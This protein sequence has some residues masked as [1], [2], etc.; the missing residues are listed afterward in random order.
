M[1][2]KLGN[3]SISKLYLGGTEIKKAYLGSDLIFLSSQLVVVFETTGINETI[4]LPISNLYPIDWGD[5]NSTT[6]ETSHEYTSIGEYTITITENVTDWSFNNAG[7]KDKILDVISLSGFDINISSFYGCSNLVGISSTSAPE[8]ILSL[9]NTFRN[10]SSLLSVSDIDKWDTSSVTTMFN[11]FQN[12]T[13]FNS[14]LVFTD[15][16]SV[17]N[18]SQMFQNALAFNSPLTLDTSSVTTMGS[19]FQNAILFNQP[20]SFDTSNVNTMFQMFREADSFDQPLV[21]NTIKVTAMNNM[22]REAI[23]FDQSLVFN[24]V[25]VTAMQNMFFGATSF[26]G[27]LTFT[28]TSSVTNMSG[29]FQ[30]ATSFNQ[31]LSFDTSNVTTMLSMFSGSTAFNKDIS[32]LDFSKVT[33]MNNFMLGKTAADYDAINYTNLLIKWDDLGNGGLDFSINTN[34]NITMGTIKYTAAGSAARASLV[35]KGYVIT[36]GGLV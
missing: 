33:I 25:M 21:F 24:T 14:P 13:L 9:Q 35:L 11:M 27:S 30:N 22:F 16:S 1:T 20:L 28:D 29:M 31:S 8:N 15:T 17:S 32:N 26:N 5:G 7:D 23:S 19:M 12:T 2:I 34:V 36:D 3:T 6:T 4:Q 10:C 18:M